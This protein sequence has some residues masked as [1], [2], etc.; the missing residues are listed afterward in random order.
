MKRTVA[1][2]VACGVLLATNIVAFA[3]SGYEQSSGSAGSTRVTAEVGF[4]GTNAYAK[5]TATD[6]V[7][8]RMNGTVTWYGASGPISG[9]FDQRTYGEVSRNCPTDVIGVNC[10][11]DVSSNDGSW[12]HYSYAY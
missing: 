8:A 4:N 5:V 2:F 10:Q 12:S 7:D 9:G 11:F 1:A 6:Y 3:G